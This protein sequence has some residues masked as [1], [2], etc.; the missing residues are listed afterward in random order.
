M[1]DAA[2]SVTSTN[3]SRETEARAWSLILDEVPI[4]SIVPGTLTAIK[5]KPN[6]YKPGARDVLAACRGEEWQ[7]GADGKTE[8][9]VC[10]NGSAYETWDAIK[11]RNAHEAE[12]ALPEPLTPLDID[13]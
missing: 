12:H 5:N 8:R 13:V 10:A 2:C 7:T 11:A 9:V 6:S 3:E 1:R 4:E